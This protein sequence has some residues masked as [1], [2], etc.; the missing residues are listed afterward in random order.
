MGGSPSVPDNSAQIAASKAQQDSLTQRANEL[1]AN[2]EALAAKATSQFNARRR[3]QSG[4]A[5]L[6]STSEQG[7]VKTAT[8]APN[9]LGI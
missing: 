7:V 8:T 3:N 9:L 2:K 4:R 1:Q 6:I 5:T